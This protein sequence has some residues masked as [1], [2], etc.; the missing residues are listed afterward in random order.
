MMTD[1][2]AHSREVHQPIP[3]IPTLASS[4]FTTPLFGLSNHFQSNE[5]TTQ[6]VTTGR[7]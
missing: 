1:G 5:T 6:L 3:S 2:I 7:K 4:Q